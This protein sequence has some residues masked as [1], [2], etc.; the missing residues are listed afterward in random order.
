M[1]S[2]G[3]EAAQ[4]RVEQDGAGDARSARRGS[5]PGTR[6][7][8]SR[9]S[10]VSVLA[11]AVQLLGRDA[12]VAQRAARRA[13]GGRGDRAEAE[14]RARRADDAVEAGVRDLLA[15][16]RRSRSSMCRTSFRSSRG[17][18]GSLLTNRS[19]RRMTPSLKLRPASIAGPVPC[20]ISTLPPPMSMTTTDLAGHADAVDRRHVDEPRLFGAG[21]DARPDAGL[22]RD[23]L[24]EL[25]AV[26]G[27][28]HGAG[29]DGD[30]FVDACAIRPAA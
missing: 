25:A 18:I 22:L 13:L 29:G 30:D 10:A 5:S 17:E 7:R 24:Q 26:L 8:F 28:A 27:L 9:S 2:V 20:V 19:V 16:T 12:A 4:Q 21:D 11:D 6:S 14:D 1:I 15:G 3:A 23:G